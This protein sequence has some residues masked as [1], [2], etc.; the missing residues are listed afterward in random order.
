MNGLWIECRIHSAQQKRDVG[1]GVADAA[2]FKI[3]AIDVED[4][5]AIGKDPHKAKLAE[6]PARALEELKGGVK[7][8]RCVDVN[9]E[10]FCH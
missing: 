8:A 10:R 3:I 2:Y 9:R 5:H 6:F 4:L 7:R 1:S